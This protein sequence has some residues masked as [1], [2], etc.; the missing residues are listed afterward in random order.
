MSTLYAMRM[1][2][3]QTK[4]THTGIVTIKCKLGL[5]RVEELDEMTAVSVALWKFRE[6]FGCGGYNEFT[7]K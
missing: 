6:F 4:N 1:V 3:K 2:S 5:W 7:F